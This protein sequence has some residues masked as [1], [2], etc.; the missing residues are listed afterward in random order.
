MGI[1]S[2]NLPNIADPLHEFISN[3]YFPE[4]TIQ[5]AIGDIEIKVT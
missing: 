2:N 5:T 1:F 4:R 3:G